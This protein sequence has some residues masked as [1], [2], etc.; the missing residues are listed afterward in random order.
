MKIRI[1][2][3]ACLV[4]AGAAAAVAQE[5]TDLKARVASIKETLTASKAALKGYEWLETTTVS[6]NGEQKSSTEDRC[7]YDVN[8]VLQKVPVAVDQASAPPGLRGRVAKRK[9]AEIDAYMVQVKALVATYLPPD[10]ARIQACVDAGNASIAVLDPG[11]LARLD[12]HNYQKKGDTLGLEIDLVKNRLTKLSVASFLDK[13]TDTV[14][15]DA[16]LATLPDGTSYPSQTVLVASAVGIKAVTDNTGYR[17][18][19]P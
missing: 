13:A 18:T 8:G 16:T 2:L 10:A 7:Y 1:G 12:L 4:V 6:L 11:K 17:K 3:I 19:Q 14:T 5:S 15:L 9:K